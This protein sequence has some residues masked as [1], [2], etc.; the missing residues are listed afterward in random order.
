LHCTHFPTQRAPTSRYIV[1]AAEDLTAVWTSAYA[2]RPPQGLVL[3]IKSD[4]HRFIAALDF[5]FSPL[6]PKVSHYIL[7]IPR[8]GNEHMQRRIA[9]LK[10]ASTRLHVSVPI[11]L[12]CDLSSD[13]VLGVPYTLQTRLPGESSQFAFTQLNFTQRKD[14]TRKIC[15]VIPKLHESSCGNCAPVGTYDVASFKLEMQSLAILPDPDNDGKVHSLLIG[16][17]SDTYTL[18]ETTYQRWK[19]YKSTFLRKP[20][21]EWDC[22]S[23]MAQEMADC[24]YLNVSERFHVF[25]MDMPPRN[26]LVNVTDDSSVE[27]IGIL[28][29]EDA[30][31]A[32]K[33]AACRA[34][35]WLWEGEEEM[36]EANEYEGLKKSLTSELQ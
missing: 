16:G 1:C 7:R 20:R 27:I 25:P 31:S 21:A 19:D 24:G 32:P 14:L 15:K 22:C 28:G 5:P 36:D 6:R 10:F 29:W 23:K 8:W 4:L 26:I 33:Y 30:L 34:P 2:H 3:P 18:I 11:T 13:N 9:T 17:I 35:F 12:L